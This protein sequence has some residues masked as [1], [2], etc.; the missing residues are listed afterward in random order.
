MRPEGHIVVGGGSMDIETRRLE[1]RLGFVGWSALFLW[2]GGCFVAG[3]RWGITL[4]GIAVVV[5]LTQA[6]RLSLKLGVEGLWVAFG[7][8]LAAAAVWDLF[9]VPL[10]SVPLLLVATAAVL[11]LAALAGGRRRS[12]QH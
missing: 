6:V 12:H 7:I 8:L 10:P 9:H 4:V 5:W 2:V 3:L 11:L 1:R